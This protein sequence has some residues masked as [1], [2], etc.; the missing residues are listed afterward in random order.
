MC[1]DDAATRT[2]FKKARRV[3]GPSI[4]IN[5]FLYTGKSVSIVRSFVRSGRLL[6]LC[7]FYASYNSINI[8]LDRHYYATPKAIQISSVKVSERISNAK[9]TSWDISD[10]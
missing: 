2:L 4:H 9:A 10:N 3:Y 6:L 8:P 7:S 1:T 5:T